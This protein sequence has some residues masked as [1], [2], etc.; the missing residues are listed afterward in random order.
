M[1]KQHTVDHHPSFSQLMSRIQTLIFLWTP[2]G[3]IYPESFLNFFLLFN[4][5][6]FLFLSNLQTQL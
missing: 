5:F 2:K 1:V 6:L 4:K 3:F